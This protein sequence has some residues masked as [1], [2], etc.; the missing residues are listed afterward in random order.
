MQNKEN[1]LYSF[2]ATITKLTKDTSMTMY[3][4]NKLFRMLDAS[5]KASIGL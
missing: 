2:E 3:L 5:V 1:E 4:S